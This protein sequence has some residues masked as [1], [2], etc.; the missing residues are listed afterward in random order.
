MRIN[1]YDLNNPE[2]K[3]KGRIKAV[4]NDQLRTQLK[5][6]LSK[7]KPTAIAKEL[8]ITYPRLWELTNK[9][10]SFPLIFLKMLEDKYKL[11]LTKVK[12]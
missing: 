10:P 12:K 2:D 5:E 11:T 4:M 8:G 6:L 7:H 1:L 3:G 9:S